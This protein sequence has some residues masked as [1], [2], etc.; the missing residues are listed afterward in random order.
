MQ[1][2]VDNRARLVKNVLIGLWSTGSGGKI[3]GAAQ[4]NQK[5][6]VRV[7]HLGSRAQEIYISSGGHC[8]GVEARRKGHSVRVR[9]SNKA[10][11]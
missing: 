10:L 4:S 8:P 2:F 9:G 6:V 7:D 3:P 5:C 11:L 1:A